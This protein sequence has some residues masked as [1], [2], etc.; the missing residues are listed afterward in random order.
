MFLKIIKHVENWLLATLGWVN[1]DSGNGLV[2]EKP[3]DIADDF[4]KRLMICSN[5]SVILSAHL[6]KLFVNT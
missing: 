2:H 6:K 4:A 1:I 3:S 5:A